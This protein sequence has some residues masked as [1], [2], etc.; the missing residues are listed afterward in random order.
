VILL[1]PIENDKLPEEFFKE[2]RNID[3]SHIVHHMAN[4]HSIK[5]YGQSLAATLTPCTN[6][7]VR[8]SI[9]LKKEKK[10]GP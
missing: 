6:P 5:T 8:A 2:K 7:S 3:T 10:G 1:F 9:P 4:I